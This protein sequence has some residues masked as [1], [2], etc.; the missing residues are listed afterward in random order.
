MNRTETLTPINEFARLFSINPV[1][2]FGVDI[3]ACGLADLNVCCET[4][5]ESSW[6][7]RLSRELLRDKIDC[8]EKEIQLI[9]GMPIAPTWVSE[10][11]FIGPTVSPQ[12]KL[13]RT[14][15][16][17]VLTKGI[18]S[19]GVRGLKRVTTG[20]TTLSVADNDGDTFYETATFT[21]TNVRKFDLDQIKFYL[22]GYPGQNS[23]SVE[24]IRNSVSYNPD[25]YTLTASFLTWYLVKPELLEGSVL[26]GRS[27]VN[28]C[29]S[30]DLNDSPLLD[31]ESE[32][33]EKLVEGLEI[34]QEFND[35]SANSAWLRY[36]P[37]VCCKCDSDVCMPDCTCI[38]PYVEGCIIIEE[39]S[40][41]YVTVNPLYD[42]PCCPCPRSYDSV[43]L[44][45]Y[46]GCCGE[47]ECSLLRKAA[48]Y[49]AAARMPEPCGCD[50]CSI[51]TVSMT[52]MAKFV[53]KPED[54]N[55]WEL[56][57]SMLSETPFGTRLGEVL[58]W[59]IIK[60]IIKKKS[61]NFAVI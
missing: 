15:S 59:Q 11:F 54:G 40:S 1:S 9:L 32:V 35:C 48:L 52:G 43:C 23:Y 58:A 7:G 3:K 39:G 16:F 61:I 55:E 38:R 60:Q 24:P 26:R 50:V 45:F 14:L 49:I 25:T 21:F 20:Q 2:F 51:N 44:N 30:E 13:L 47:I 29:C 34:Y 22:P 33:K 53:N 46:A 28:L 19:P 5:S 27:T 57:E 41:G 37:S 12:G 10:D 6:D 42:N 17:N 8:A 31:C 36:R 18:I 56:T 4:W